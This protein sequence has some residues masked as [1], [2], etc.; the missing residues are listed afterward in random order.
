MDLLNLM[1]FSNY[2][3]YSMADCSAVCETTDLIVSE[4]GGA[5]LILNN[6]MQ[7]CGSGAEYMAKVSNSG[8]ISRVSSRAPTKPRR[9]FVTAQAPTPS[10]VKFRRSLMR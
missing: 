9:S 3:A 7:S 6:E 4:A 2:A 8:N 5:V 10:T 1:M